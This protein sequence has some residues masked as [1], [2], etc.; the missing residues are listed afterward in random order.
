M[1]LEI[2]SPLWL[3]SNSRQ[4][5]PIGNGLLSREGPWPLTFP[6]MPRISLVFTFNSFQHLQTQTV[7]PNSAALTIRLMIS[8]IGTLIQTARTMTTPTTVFFLSLQLPD[9]RKEMHQLHNGKQFRLGL[10]VYLRKYVTPVSG[11]VL[12]KLR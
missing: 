3:F 12:S 7:M 9:W 2:C 4:F 1:L 8:S 11:T 6:G 10:H 5:Y